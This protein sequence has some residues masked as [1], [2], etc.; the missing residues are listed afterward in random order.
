MVKYLYNVK[1][2][3]KELPLSIGSVDFASIGFLL[4]LCHIEYQ[5][6]GVGAVGLCPMLN[7][8]YPFWSE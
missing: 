5:P 8:N 3:A 2:Y 1:E 6:V 4:S 7:T